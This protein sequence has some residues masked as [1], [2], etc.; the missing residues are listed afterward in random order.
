M[1]ITALKPKATTLDTP[2]YAIKMTRQM[3]EEIFGGK[4]RDIGVGVT[5]TGWNPKWY[6][7]QLPAIKRHWSRE[8]GGLS[9]VIAVTFY[10]QRSLYKLREEGYHLAGRC[11]VE[12]QEV[13]GY[14]SDIMV[15][16]EDRLFVIA[17]ISIRGEA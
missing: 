4:P 11:K 6:T 1:T 16:V 3:F 9:K 15:E 17:V 8:P 2:E 7:L 13:A 5:T 10:G 12:G 14:T